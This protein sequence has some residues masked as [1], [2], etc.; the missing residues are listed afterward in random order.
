V[1]NGPK[2]LSFDDSFAT[3][4][5]ECHIP[6]GTW[7]LGPQA[8]W[9]STLSDSNDGVVVVDDG[10]FLEEFPIA[11][12]GDL[13]V[14][15]VGTTPCASV[16]SPPNLTMSG[17]ASISA[18]TAALFTNTDAGAAFSIVMH[19]A[20]SIQNGG[21][22]VVSSAQLF[23]G[24]YDQAFLDADAVTAS[25]TLFLVVA[26]TASVSAT[27]LGGGVFTLATTSNPLF[28]QTALGTPVTNTTAQTTLVGAG[29]GFMTMWRG[30]LETAGVVLDL[31]LEGI[32]TTSAMANTIQVKVLKG[33]TVLGQTVSGGAAITAAGGAS[34]PSCYWRIRL[35]IAMFTTTTAFVTGTFE[36]T[37]PQ[38]Q[39]TP[40][41]TPLFPPLGQTSPVTIS[42]A[43]ELLDVQVAWGT[44]ATTSSIQSTACTLAIAYPPLQA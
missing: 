9:T 36:Y 37:T 33:S 6:E 19:D 1:L 28:T 20:S 13:D 40:V 24:L 14:N 30:L 41:V 15:M 2:T 34:L 10:A 25:T 32:V 18:A 43:Q 38:T 44:A 3:G 31:C 27:Q 12:T 39:G 21:A 5:G 26:P 4:D 8:T 17:N 7:S 16:A 23:I 35:K 22:A 29:I 11:L 42:S